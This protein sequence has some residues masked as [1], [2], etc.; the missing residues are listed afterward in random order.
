MSELGLR[1]KNARAEKNIS[2]EEL[3]SITKIQKR[4]LQAIEE[5]NLDILPGT[6]YARGFVKSYADAVGIDPDILFEEHASELP[7]INKRVE[8][9]PARVQQK[10][11]RGTKKTLRFLAV[12]PLVIVVV[13]IISIFI[14]A[15]FYLQ[16][17]SARDEATEYEQPHSPS[18]EGGR[19]DDALQPAKGGEEAIE[20]EE[21]IIEEEEEEVNQEVEVVET[22]GKETIY[23]LI[24]AKEFKFKI[25][26]VGK[27]YVEIDNR[28]GK[29][30]HALT[31]DGGKTLKFDFSEEE[32]IQ[33]NFGA[34]NNV[35]LFINE[36]PFEFPLDI[37]HQKVTFHFIQESAD[38]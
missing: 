27:S 16:D 29:T 35:K 13:F 11:K 22:K 37:V 4:Y 15:W 31:E 18:V 8:E 21:E 20:I 3:Q 12:L 7:T 34:S 6:F 32:T 23:N 9:I 1:L 25:D 14:G 5:G 33:F 30:F 36:E 10:K 26:L 28:K 19:N 17:D 24:N 2:L 38:Q